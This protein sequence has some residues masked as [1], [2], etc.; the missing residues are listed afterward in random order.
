VE[1]SFP[2]LRVLLTRAPLSLF[3]SSMLAVLLGRALLYRSLRARKAFKG[4]DSISSYLHRA[5]GKNRQKQLKAKKELGE[6]GASVTVGLSH[7][8]DSKN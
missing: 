2:G 7:G 4:Q 6:I 5:D 8:S 1:I 3:V